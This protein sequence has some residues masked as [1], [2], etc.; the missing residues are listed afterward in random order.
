MTAPA[1][2][3]I[4]SGGESLLQSL[5][6]EHYLAGAGLKTAP[7]LQPIYK[8]HQRVVSEDSLGAALEVVRGTAATDPAHRSARA[9]AEWLAEEQASR[10]LAP[11]DEREAAWE[12]SAVVSL[13]DGRSVPYE[14]VAID[15]ANATDRAERLLLDRH[16]ATLVDA[17]L[18]PMRRERLQRE[19]ELIEALD[20]GDGYI[21]TFEKLSGV[22]LASLAAQCERFLADTQG[23]WDD[24]LARA[25]KRDLQIMPREATRADALALFRARRF[26]PAFP[27]ND[28]EPTIRRQVAEMGIDATA[29]GR[30]VYDTGE[31]DGK[32]SRAFCAPVRIPDE[33]YLVMRPHGGQTDWN[34]FLHELGHAMHFAFMRSDLEFE[35][36]WLGDNGVTEAF[37]MLFDHRMMDAGWL[38]RYTGLAQQIGDFRRASA[39][40]ELHFLRR[41][42]AKLLY[43][44]EL[45][46]E[47]NWDR[48]PDRYVDRLTSA[49]TFQYRPSDAFVDIDFRFYSSR[50]LRA[51]QLQAVIDEALRDRFNEDWWRNPKAGPWIVGEL[52]APGQREMAEEMASRVSGKSLGF[53]PLVRAIENALQ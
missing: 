48:L 37:A 34:T 4:R 42:C 30:I 45:Y 1:L 27:A 38:K 33:V 47:S 9:I 31:R 5:S 40:E 3:S 13:P 28:L 17:E 16:R 39:L 51:W 43:E 46:S 44:R 8:R 2:D 49:T 24:V 41:Y 32:R 26:D 10:T 19:R 52:F 14:Q 21:A 20:I 29:N 35:W 25:L 23:M 22:P 18:S 6:R 53:E 12:A 15:M 7:D 11:L 50:Y 36:R